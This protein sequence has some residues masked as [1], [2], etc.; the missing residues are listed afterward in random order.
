MK[1]QI[2]NFLKDLLKGWIALIIW[3]I[4]IIILF[5][6]NQITS[7]LKFMVFPKFIILILIGYFFSLVIKLVYFRKK[8]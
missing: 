6:F 2:K 4:I 5:K 7:T 1:E 3:T 8:N